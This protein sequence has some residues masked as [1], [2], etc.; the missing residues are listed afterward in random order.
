MRDLDAGHS[1][2]QLLQ[3]SHFVKTA[4]QLIKDVD[5]CEVSEEFLVEIKNKY[6]CEKHLSLQ[7]FKKEIGLRKSMKPLEYINLILKCLY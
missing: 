5:G 7:F 4:T 3:I 1:N 2:P 6:M